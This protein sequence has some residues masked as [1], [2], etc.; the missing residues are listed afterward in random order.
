MAAA[1]EEPRC[2]TNNLASPHLH[3]EDD[4]IVADYDDDGLDVTVMLMTQVTSPSNFTPDT[5]AKLWYTPKGRPPKKKNV[6]FRAL[7][8]S[9]GE[10]TARLFLPFFNKVMGPKICQFLLKSHNICMFFLW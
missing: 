4:A 1:W 7:P 2:P 10:A 6:Y 8:K 3:C 9:G 5:R